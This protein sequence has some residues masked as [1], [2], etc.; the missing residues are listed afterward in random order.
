MDY[1]AEVMWTKCL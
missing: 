1:R